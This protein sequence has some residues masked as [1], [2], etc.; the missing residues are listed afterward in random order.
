MVIVLLGDFSDLLLA[1]L[2]ANDY[3]PAFAMPG[4]DAIKV[5]PCSVRRKRRCHVM[6]PPG[7]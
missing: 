1:V 6:L 3:Y 4:F 2:Y 5:E 7:P